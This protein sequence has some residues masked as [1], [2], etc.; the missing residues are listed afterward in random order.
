MK[1]R[2]NLFGRLNLFLTA[3]F[4]TVSLFYAYSHQ[5]TVHVLGLE[6][7]QSTQRQLKL[8][9]NDVEFKTRQMVS[10]LQIFLSEPYA[11]KFA[12]IP[13][14][15]T[16]YDWLEIRR[17][18]QERIYYQEGLS[19]KWISRFAIYS[20]FN[21][22]AVSGQ[23]P[24][25]Y[26]SDYLRR[27]ISTK[28]KLRPVELDGVQTRAFYYYL[29]DTV[30]AQN[31]SVIIEAM[32]P[33]SNLR[34]MLD[35]MKLSG[36]G[37]PFLYE[38]RGDWITG[39]SAA[40]DAPQTIAAELDE[41]ALVGDSFN[42]R[43]NMDGRT[44]VV[45]GVRSPSLNWYLVDYVPLDQVIS[46]I[47]ETNFLFYAALTLLFALGVVFSYLL[48]RNVLTP[49]KQLIGGLQRVKRG[50][51]NT[52]IYW[53]K[54]VEFS[55]VFQQFNEMTRQTRQLIEHVLLEQLRAKDAMLKQLQA[56]INPHFLYNCLGFIINMTEMKNERAVVR[57]AHSLSEY[58][59]F[60]TRTDLGSVALR[61]ELQVVGSYLDIQKMRFS[62]LSFDISVPEPM[63]PLI[64]PRL[65]LQPIV[66]N[67]IEH[68]IAKSLNAGRLK[69]VG[70]EDERQYTLRVEDDGTRLTGQAL[71]ELREALSAPGQP[72]IGYG[73]W[74]IAQRL[75][76]A[77]DG[78]AGIVLERSAWGGLSVT[79][80]IPKGDPISA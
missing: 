61:D 33:E 13:I 44:F 9:S 41:R 21:K 1:W 53:D 34:D 4:L 57:M 51:Y 67:A 16:N 15:R 45:S 36:P 58:Y 18:L 6:I 8:L 55:Y 20:T 73:L 76:Y 22:E 62:R 70:S 79:I 30:V 66:E 31:A 60:I 32:F 25:A 80:H 52:N 59:R 28:W 46:P 3:V 37:T 78:N 75:L 12:S 43:V 63:L 48:H 24:A 19:D 27:N 50:D 2:K 54:D 68:G 38:H 71:S 10:F 64:I 5:R 47:V 49:L 65:L 56:Q 11:K 40:D 74:N 69:I 29:T 7:E 42:F 14:D 23:R 72:P 17:G 26:D 77:Y 35:E 39:S